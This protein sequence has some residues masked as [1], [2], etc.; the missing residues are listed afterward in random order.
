MA[1][2]S[3]SVRAPSGAHQNGATARLKS[4]EFEVKHLTINHIFTGTIRAEPPAHV[5]AH[6]SRK[7]IP[8]FRKTVIAGLA[9]L[10]PAIGLAAEPAPAEATPPPTPEHTITGNVGLFSQYIFRGLTQTNRNPAV[11][12]GFDYAHSSGFYA[13][14][15]AS[16]ISWLRENASTRAGGVTV[17]NGTYGDGG[18]LEWDFYGGYKGTVKDFSYDVGTLY[19]WYPGKINEV[20]A[21]APAPFNN[22]PK[23]DTWEIY[24]GGGW[25]WLT[26]KF[27]YSIMNKTF[28]VLD[29]RGTWY[30][31]LSANV[32]LGDYYK[33][34]TGFTAMA[35]WGYQKYRGTDP[36]NVGFAPAYGGATPNNDTIASYK[37]VK[38]GLSYALPKDFTVGA[39]YSKAYNAN[40]L[41]YGSVTEASGGG[42]FGPYPHN[43]AKSTGTVYVQKTF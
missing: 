5:L 39:Y 25:K 2:R 35:H 10:A 16:N 28:G 1:F 24:A 33:P 32:P 42:L 29:S 43:I 22:V 38:L 4:V 37:D 13:G 14:T 12:G 26:A 41:G 21:L 40:T 6:H 30:L 20:F 36:R 3:N 18:S 7:G 23:A 8:M 27:S 19:Y 9:A 17:A 11:Q 34:L 31:D 15:W